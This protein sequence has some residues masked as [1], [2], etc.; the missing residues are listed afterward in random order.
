[1]SGGHSIKQASLSFRHHLN[2]EDPD[3]NVSNRSAWILGRA[4]GACSFLHELDRTFANCRDIEQCAIRLVWL[5]GPSVS[6]ISA[7]CDF[8]AGKSAEARPS[9]LT[10]SRQESNRWQGLVVEGPLSKGARVMSA[11]R[12]SER[13]I[14]VVGSSAKGID[15]RASDVDHMSRRSL[16]YKW[17]QEDRVTHFVWMRGLAIFYGCI[18]LVLFAVIAGGKPSHLAH[19][20]P[21]SRSDRIADCSAMHRESCARTL[22]GD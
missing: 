9:R 5:I 4:C 18:L 11:S 8:A 2:A 10:A 14:P 12:S 1:M 3:R 17:T 16:T 22:Q 13:G 19:N 15:I 21:S 7:A 20:G 6:R